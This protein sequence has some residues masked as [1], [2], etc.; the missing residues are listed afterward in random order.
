MFLTLLIISCVLASSFNCSFLSVFKFAFCIFSLYRTFPKT[1]L[2][3]GSFLMF[4]NVCHSKSGSRVCNLKYNSTQ[5]GTRM[6]SNIR[7]CVSGERSCDKPF[8]LP[9]DTITKSMTSEMVYRTFPLSSLV[10]H[11]KVFPRTEAID[12]WYFS[13][14]SS[15]A[16]LTSLLFFKHQ[17]FLVRGSQIWTDLSILH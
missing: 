12:S 16:A 17:L 2:C 7:A 4:S 15:R 11:K 1:T 8:L 14:T 9:F 6:L 5:S 10:P 3:D 13:D